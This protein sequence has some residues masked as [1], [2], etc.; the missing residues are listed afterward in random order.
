[1]YVILEQMVDRIAKALAL[2]GGIVMTILIVVTCLSI[3]G[4]SLTFAGLDQIDGDF[5]IMELGIGFAIFCFLPWAHL[6]GGHARVEMLRS[7]FGAKGN[8]VLDLIADVLVFCASVV[9]TRQLWLGMLDKKSYL[10]TT[11]ILQFPVWQ[12]YLAASVGAFGFVLIAGFCVL[13]ST[14]KLMHK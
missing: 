7:L 14:R 5:E 6:S 8:A 9:L 12:S 1:M 11:F 10:E 13:R 4:R 2:L 3:V